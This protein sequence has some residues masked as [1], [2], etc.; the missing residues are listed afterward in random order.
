MQVDSRTN[1]DL[2]Y[3]RHLVRPCAEQDG[4]LYR[5]IDDLSINIFADPFNWRTISDHEVTGELFWEGYTHHVVDSPDLHFTPTIAEVLRQLPPIDDERMV[6]TTQVLQPAIFDDQ[7]CHLAW[8][9]LYK[10]VNIDDELSALMSATSLVDSN[11]VKD[12]LP[13]PIFPQTV[14]CEEMLF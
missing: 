11:Q 2:L 9:K 4:R 7:L 5:L 14:P 8:T 3:L 13:S 6:F 1:Q 12:R 10:V